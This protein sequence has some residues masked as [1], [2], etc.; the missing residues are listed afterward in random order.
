MNEIMDTNSMYKMEFMPFIGKDYPLAK[1][2]TLI[3]GESHHCDKL[4][5]CCFKRNS[6]EKCKSLTND[7][8]DDY[9]NYKKTGKGFYK[10]LNTFTKFSNV[11]EG[12]KLNNKETI[13]LW[14]TFIFYNYVQFPM[15]GPRKSPDFENFQKSEKALQDL[16]KE[17][18]PNLIIFWG[19]R[20][21]NNFPKSH[22]VEINVNEEKISCIKV[23]DNIYPILVLPHP[24]STKLNDSY[25][26]IIKKQIELT[27]L[28]S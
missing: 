4:E 13:G 6:L 26:Q 14:E 1:Y 5:N 17:S 3:L 7:V 12:K 15:E 22:I 19:Y 2:K 21:W 9:I 8:I 10:S 23:E 18:N 28:L 20:L 27:K 11:F 25:S 24:S 16:L